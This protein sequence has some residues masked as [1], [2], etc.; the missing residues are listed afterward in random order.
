MFFLRQKEDEQNSEEGGGFM[1][2]SNINQGV[3]QSV[4]PPSTCFTC[5]IL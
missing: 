3:F 1:D 2:T 5:C 4:L